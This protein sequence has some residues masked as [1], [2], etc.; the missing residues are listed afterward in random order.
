MSRFQKVLHNI[1]NL[2]LK[3]RINS[4]DIYRAETP[5]SYFEMSEKC[6]TEITGLLDNS[7]L[8]FIFGMTN[9]IKANIMS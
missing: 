6:Y 4:S 9:V 2:L 7:A 8:L 1:K 5:G 3:I